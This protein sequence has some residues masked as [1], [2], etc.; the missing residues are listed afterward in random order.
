MC[1]FSPSSATGCALLKH[2]EVVT[3]FHGRGCT[4]CVPL[5]TEFPADNIRLLELGHGIHDLLSRTSHTRYH[6]WRAPAEFAE[7]LSTMLENWCWNQSDLKEMSCHYA[8]VTPDYLQ[9]WKAL[10]PGTKLPAECIPDELL[11]RLIGGRHLTK[12]LGLLQQ[13]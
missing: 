12:A 8:R 11:D 9:Q 3:L 1:N 6:A 13:T 7:A 4:Y 10:H 5:G 2:S